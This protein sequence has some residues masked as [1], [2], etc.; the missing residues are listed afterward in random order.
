[1]CDYLS[2]AIHTVPEPSVDISDDGTPFNGSVY[3]LIC[4]VTVDDNVDTNITISSQWILPNDMVND[5]IISNPSELEQ[6][7]TLTFEPLRSEDNGTYI[8]NISITPEGEDD[9]FIIGTSYNET[10]DVI[11]QSKYIDYYVVDYNIMNDIL[12]LVLPPPEV[13]IDLSSSTTTG[14]PDAVANNDNT[15]TLTCMAVVDSNL[16][17]QPNITLTRDGDE[18][19][20]ISSG[21]SLTYPLSPSESGV[22]KCTV[23]INI[24]EAGI[25]DHCSSTVVTISSNGKYIIY[26]TTILLVLLMMILYSLNSTRDNDCYS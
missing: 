10:K 26:S 7:H 19:D 6:Q 5:E 3:G 9:E 16:F 1:M 13:I 14:C 15:D 12:L 22:Y 2:S 8:C 17:N 4:T 25:V 24:P 18:L 11:V 21:V 23:C 20:S